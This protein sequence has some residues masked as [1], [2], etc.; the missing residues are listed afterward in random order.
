[1]MILNE[2]QKTQLLTTLQEIR[3]DILSLAH[4]GEDML[5]WTLPGYTGSSPGDTDHWS[6]DIFNGNSGI[7]LFFLELYRYTGRN[8]DL[9]TVRKI[10]RFILRNHGRARKYCSFYTGFTGIIYLLIRVYET[11]GEKEV[12]RQALSL[13]SANREDLV[14]QPV[15]AD[16]LSGYAGNL[17]VLVHLYHYS[18]DEK[19]LHSIQRLLHRFTEEARI[20]ETGLKWDYSAAKSAYDSM[21]GFS[22][23]AS[24]IA[25]VLLQTGNYFHNDG[26][27]YLAEQ[28]LAYEMQYFYPESGN[29]LDLRMGPY[30]L[31]LKEAHR[32]DLDLFIPTMR[33]VNSWAHG[34]SGI[35]IARLY[36]Y[37][38]TGNTAYLDQCRTVL[39]TSLRYLDKNERTDYTLCSGYTGHIPF[40][41]KFMPYS[42]QYGPELLTDIIDRASKLHSETHVY[43]TYTEANRNDCGL[44]SGKAGV[45]YGLLHLLNPSLNSI[46]MPS[47]PRRRDPVPP[48]SL[49]R[50]A[51]R[52]RIFRNYYPKTLKALQLKATGFTGPDGP[53]DISAL[54]DFIKQQLKDLPETAYRTRKTY[55]LEYARTALWKTHKG[56]LC[57]N[58]KRKY[59]RV[60]TEIYDKRSAIQLLNT[61]FCLPDH[62]RLFYGVP[63][64]DKNTET[65]LRYFALLLLCDE[66]GVRDIPL[67]KFQALLLSELETE[68]TPGDIADQMLREYFSDQVKT[69]EQLLSFKGTVVKQFMEFVKAGMA[70]EV[71]I[72]KEEVL[73]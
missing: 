69:P 29:W 27:L 53:Q 41:R 8:R 36:A 33:N 5:W 47:L 46:C 68:N 72:T 26:L 4:T 63:D 62:V 7:A 16:L 61:P 64:T 17:L 32:W 43:N 58:V 60:H 40:L 67:G 50:E 21:T 48:L 59:L 22:H 18:R 24:G 30:R 23:G 3:T 44:L 39:T 31:G 1:M 66:D 56:F 15:K 11:T 14:S 9:E 45:G 55:D 73:K 2:T 13:A 20:S 28:A 35:G 25:Y 65:G 49:T 42:D 10:I 12:L 71:I 54:E 51:I 52:T 34:A 37:E 6:A 19:V 70:E 38:I 57:Y